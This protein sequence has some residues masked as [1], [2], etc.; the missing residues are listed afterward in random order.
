VTAPRRTRQ[1]H[2]LVYVDDPLHVDGRARTASTDRADWLHDL[3]AAVLFTSPGERVHRPDFG[4]GLLQLVFAGASQESATTVQFLVMGSLQQW[5]G[6]LVEITEVLTA[7]APDEI[8]V[9][10]TYTERL[11]G[12]QRT[13]EF[14]SAGTS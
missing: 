9:T 2:E 5:V 14:T 4:S 10:V 11:T 3:I 13:E 6:H 1:G 7:G 8:A 12:V